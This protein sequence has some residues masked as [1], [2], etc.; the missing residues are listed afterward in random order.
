[1]YPVSSSIGV[2]G[3]GSP[4]NCGSAETG[5]SNLPVSYVPSSTD[6]FDS[7]PHAPGVRFRLVVDLCKGIPSEKAE[8]NRK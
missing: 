6:I 1:M 2:G 3:F 5:S 7:T 4:G 8:V